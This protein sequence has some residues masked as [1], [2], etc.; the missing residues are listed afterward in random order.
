MPG[1]TEKA[2]SHNA[3]I[4]V[5]EKSDRPIVPGKLPNKAGAAEAM[6]GRGLVK[7]NV[8]KYRGPDAVPDHRVIG[9]SRHTSDRSQGQTISFQYLR[10]EPYA[11]ILPVRI[12]A[13][14][15]GNPCPHRA[16]AQ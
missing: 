5:D 6:E 14:A 4:Y 15:R 11:V 8:G 10:Q 9:T 3:V 12:C 7:G 16:P 2:K 13:G 1:G